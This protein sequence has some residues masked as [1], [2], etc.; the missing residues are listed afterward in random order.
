VMSAQH[1]DFTKT[2]DVLDKDI[3]GQK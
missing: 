3:N 1:F 2:S